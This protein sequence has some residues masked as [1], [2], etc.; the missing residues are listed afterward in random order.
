MSNNS[1][2]KATV[3]SRKNKKNKD[4]SKKPR[5]ELSSGAQIVIDSLERENVNVIFGVIGGAIMPV[6]DKLGRSK[7]IR[8]ITTAHEQGA[9]HA[10]D[11]YARVTGKPG[12]CM[13]TSGPGAANL[14]TGLAT[15]YM[16]SS[17]VIGL[18]GQVPTKL[19]GRDSFQEVD[20]RGISDSITKHNYLVKRPHSIPQTIKEAFHLSQ[21]GRPGPIIIDLPKDVQTSK[22]NSTGQPSSSV[23]PEG[24]EVREK[25]TTEKIQPLINE[26]RRSQKPL[27]LAGGG[28][29]LSGA[30]EQLT[31][32]ADQFSIPVTFSLMG[33]GSFPPKS[34]LHLGML[35]MHGTAVANKAISECDFL[36][37][38]GTRLDDRMTGDVSSFAPHASL[39][40]IDIDTSEMGKIVNPAFPVVADAKQALKKIRDSLNQEHPPD[41]TTWLDQIKSWREKYSRPQTD[42][43]QLTSPHVIEV[44]DDLTP[45][46]SII[47]TGVGQHQMWVAQKY[48]FHSPRTLITSGGLG[49][50]GYGFPAAIG[51]KIAAP[52]KTIVCITGD[53][54]FQMNIQELAT[55][56]KEE[57][58]ITVVVL[59]NGYLGMVRQWQE[60][61]FDNHI[62]ETDINENIPSFST[63]TNSYG[64]LGLE[65]T[66]NQD[67][68]KTLTEAFNYRKGPSV[69]ECFVKRDENVFPM[70]P[71]GASNEE[72]ILGENDANN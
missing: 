69:V 70:V 60:L 15:A 20:M 63:V 14:V 72:F 56:V 8:H 9:I 18:T 30:S 71:A 64:G 17:P 27:V 11:A 19:I 57:L 50:M 42:K 2:Q 68:R 24:Y 53:G 35:G 46:D 62:Y 10:A 32:L 65:V 23:Q 4:D 38:V 67:L 44:I 52:H 59:R 54:S 43:K 26:L 29:I 48:A 37:A 5:K 3:N 7:S 16:D 47:T 13:A 34:R 51:A 45:K 39:A 25:L 61:F 40:H 58:D 36:L 22:C 41:T 31:Q 12:V 49:T 66:E 6:Y 1:F 33:L 28:V 21:T 55:A